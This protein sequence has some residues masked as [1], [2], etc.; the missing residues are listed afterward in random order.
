[1]RQTELTITCT[2]D[3][4]SRYPSGGVGKL[5]IALIGLAVLLGALIIWD[6]LMAMYL[7]ILAWGLKRWRDQRRAREADPPR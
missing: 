1:M 2:N 3:D 7:T 6:V 4:L 5:R